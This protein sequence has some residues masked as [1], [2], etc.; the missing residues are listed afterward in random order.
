MRLL[1]KHVWRKHVLLITPIL[2]YMVLHILYF[3]IFRRYIC[4][5]VHPSFVEDIKMTA[6]FGGMRQ[7]V[8]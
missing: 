3:T 8:G 6:C 1:S 2:L 4:S 7:Y 5:K